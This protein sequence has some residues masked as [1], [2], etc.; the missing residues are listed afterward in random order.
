MDLLLTA[1]EQA[2]V[3]LPLVLG[4]YISFHILNVTDL[5]VDG[6]YVLG[7]ALFGS[8]IHFG[9][10]PAMMLTILGGACVGFVVSMMQRNNIVDSLVVGILASFMLYSIN[11][12]CMG[13]PNISVLGMPT[14]MSQMNQE[15]WIVPLGILG[16]LLIIVLTIL[17]RSRL[18]LLLRSFGQNQKLLNILGKNSESYRLLGLVI[19][20]ALAAFSGSLAAQV[21]GFADIIMGFGVALVSIGAIVVGKHILIKRHKN[22][23]SLKEIVACCIGIFLYFICLSGL[24][25]IGINPVNLKLALGLVLYV[26]LRKIH[27]GLQL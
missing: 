23:N 26:S 1:L 18:G 4:M 16:L 15:S 7:A 8:Y 10:V 22:F 20:N 5:T 27:R 12:Q 13:R 25:R 2:L 11:L 9:V 19:S 21:N 24:L 3:L 14:I 17:L 6:T